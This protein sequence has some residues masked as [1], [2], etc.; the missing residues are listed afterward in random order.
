M[1]ASSNSEANVIDV[2]VV[3]IR[4]LKDKGEHVLVVSPSIFPYYM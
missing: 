2:L 1:V 3:G 4:D